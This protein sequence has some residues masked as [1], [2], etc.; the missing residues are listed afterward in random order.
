MSLADIED[1]VIAPERWLSLVYNCKGAPDEMLIPSQTRILELSERVNDQDIIPSLYLVPGG[2][3]L[4]ILASSLAL[5]DVYDYASPRLIAETVIP[6]FNRD[7][8]LVHSST[9]G[10]G[11]RIFV[12]QSSGP[13]LDSNDACVI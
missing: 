8:F 10:E 1:A 4:I 5:F 7:F 13:Y 2:R 12:S 6:F 9:D 3:F 11:I